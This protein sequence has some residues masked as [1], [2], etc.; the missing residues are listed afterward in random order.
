LEANVDGEGGKLKANQDTIQVM[1]AGLI[2]GWTYSVDGREVNPAEALP[3]LQ[4][5]QAQQGGDS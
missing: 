4:V 1:L 5:R 2:K 3:E